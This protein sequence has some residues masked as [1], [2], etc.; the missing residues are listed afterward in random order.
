MSIQ[1]TCPF[2]NRPTT[3]TEHDIN[4]G[5][6]ILHDETYLR[7]VGFAWFSVRCPNTECRR[8]SLEI[9]TQ[10]WLMYPNSTTVREKRELSTWAL[11]PESN[12]RP[13]PPY[14]PE[15]IREDYREACLI[16]SK[17]PKASATLSRRCLQGMIRDFWKI[18][19]K[20]LYAEIMKLKEKVDPETWEALKAVKDVGNIGAHMEADINIIVPVDP[21]EAALLIEMI[22]QLFED[23]YVKRHQRQERMGKLRALALAKK[24]VKSG[25]AD[26]ASPTPEEADEASPAPEK[27]D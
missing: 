18:S 22:E 4:K 13:Q 27:S 9:E 11:L 10:R 5:D 23:W 20:T 14:I 7:T 21:G 16:V 12:V 25:Q 26:E 3:I 2:C 19:E 6:S 17:S 24:E 15:P 1:W 8:F